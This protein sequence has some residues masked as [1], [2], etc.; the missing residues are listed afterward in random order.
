VSRRRSTRKPKR[1]PTIAERFREMPVAF[2]KACGVCKVQV[3]YWPQG[4]TGWIKCDLGGARGAH[5]CY[6]GPS[7]PPG[8][9]GLDLEAPKPPPPPPEKEKAPEPQS[10]PGP[11]SDLWV[12]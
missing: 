5:V 12:D 2:E 9:P 7:T 1:K 6:G 8:D 4:T 10:T 11:L 3:L